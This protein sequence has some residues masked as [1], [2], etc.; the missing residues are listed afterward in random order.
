[1]IS[2]SNRRTTN[3]RAIEL[4]YYKVGSKQPNR[5]RALRFPPFIHPSPPNNRWSPKTL[6]PHCIFNTPPPPNHVYYHIHILILINLA[7][8]T[9]IA[10]R[11]TCSPT[12]HTRPPSTPTS[13]YTT[14]FVRRMDEPAA[15]V[16][17]FA[18]PFKST[19]YGCTRNTRFSPL[20]SPPTGT[21]VGVG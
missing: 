2:C 3:T 20:T 9:T 12:P 6:P 4:P 13:A 16:P 21:T 17:S 5:R 14:K 8:S 1:M 7:L 10:S 11:I 19:R 18:V 15:S